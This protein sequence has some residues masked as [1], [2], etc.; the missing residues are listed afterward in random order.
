MAAAVTILKEPKNEHIP[1][2]E[3][4][5]LYELGQWYYGQLTPEAHEKALE[6]LNQTAQADPKFVRPYAE[7]TALYIWCFL[8]GITNDQVR[9]QQTKKFAT[10]A[11]AINPESAEFHIAL[12]WCKFLERDWRGAEDEIVH[13]IKLN[14]DLAIPHDVRSFYL[15]MLDRFD[16]AHREADRAEELEPSARATA[17]VAAFPFMGE[18]RY[19]QAIAQLQRVLELDRNFAIGHSFLG[20]CYEAESNYAAAIEE[21][22]SSALLFGNDPAGVTAFYGALRQA[23]DTSGEQGYFRKWIELLRAD[24]AL[25]VEE[26]MFDYSDHDLPGYYARL[27]ENEQALDELEK[28][29]DEPNIWHQIKFFP[30]HDS[31]RNEPRF[32][33]LVKRA[34]LE[35]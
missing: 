20:D 9:L 11:M 27:G 19:D 30:L 15:T 32:K 22:K 28:H 18:R 17:I 33:A 23:Y 5:R 14:P 4:K 2:P 16:E 26:R 21:F 7:L 12:S 31:L 13:A 1:T 29:F 8:P 35:P 25:P 3:A 6:Y 34:G 24:E 10:K